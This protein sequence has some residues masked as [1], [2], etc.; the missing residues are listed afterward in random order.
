[1]WENCSYSW[2]RLDLSYRLA[3]NSRNFSTVVDFISFKLMLF[4]QNIT[5][6]VCTYINNHSS[7]DHQKFSS[8][9]WEKLPVC[10][11]CCVSLMLAILP[12]TLFQFFLSEHSVTCNIKTLER[13]HFVD[14]HIT[15]VTQDDK[16]VIATG[17]N[18]KSKQDNF[19]KQAVPHCINTDWIIC[20]IEVEWQLLLW[21]KVYVKCLWKLEHMKFS[22]I[23]HGYDL[24]MMVTCTHINTKSMVQGLPWKVDS[25][26]SGQ[27]I[28]CI[29]ETERF[30][31]LF[32]N[33]CHLI[34][35]WASLIQFICS[36]SI[37]S[38][39]WWFYHLFLVSQMCS[40]EFSD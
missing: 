24:Q 30:I 13:F 31:T 4:M 39:L 29:C 17:S 26:S 16:H 38:I 37:S 7:F 36:Q 5:F 12:I 2:H 34:L 23:K 1:M 28:P 21:W 19:C 33:T 35:S 6:G 15:H 27:E 22:S 11:F 32:T 25:Y 8:P 9:S 3:V 20:M 10:P 14:R 40:F 18:M